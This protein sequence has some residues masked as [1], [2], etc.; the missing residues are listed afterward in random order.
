[1]HSESVY[2]EQIES[3]WIRIYQDENADDP[4][5]WGLLFGTMSCFHRRYN[6]STSEKEA[7]A[8]FHDPE[9]LD[10]FFEKQGDA[11]IKLPIYMYDHSGQTIS[12]HPFSCPWD[13]GQLGYIWISKERA[14]KELSTRK[15]K[16]PKRWSKS[17][18]KRVYAMLE[19][20]IKT[21][22]DWMTGNVYGDVLHSVW[23]YYG[24]DEKDGSKRYILEE[25]RSQAK[26]ELEEQQ[27]LAAMC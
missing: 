10:E 8:I 27:K 22:D 25:A 6:L 7:E 17:A 12:T 4:R 11:I 20:T 15:G 14:L 9:G 19:G 1:M 18:E 13:S 21:I 23:G 16:T 24:F 26:S 2:E 3:L 5:D